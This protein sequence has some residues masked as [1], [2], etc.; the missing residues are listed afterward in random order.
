METAQ[1]EMTGQPKLRSVRRA[2]RFGGLRVFMALILREMSATNGRAAGGYLWAFLE[3]VLGIALLTAI[4][5]LGFRTPRLGTNFPI[6][7]AT[8]ML[9]FFMFI[10]VS[11]KIA[12]SINYSRALLAYPAVTY[13]DAILARFVLNVLTQLL[14]SYAVLTGILLAF[15]TRTTL[16]IDRVLLC[17]SMAAA[18]G[19]GV[20]ILN[21]FLTSMFP[22]WQKV[23]SV[24]TRPLILVSG[25]IFLPEVVPEPYRGWLMW[26]PLI[27]V[28]GE[29]R[30]AF[31]ASYTADYVSAPYVFGVALIAGATGLIFLRRY[32][33]DIL[34]L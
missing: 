9:P 16:E 13:A 22:V 8:G 27:H 24:L 10:D 12:Q 19:L 3:P 14:V 31:Y 5:S 17:Y 20:G 7:Y 34:E 23:W 2:R 26:N 33:R 11:S 18:L 1:A 4:F 28:T 25:V 21:C 15:E 30:G 29:M 6:F 32:H